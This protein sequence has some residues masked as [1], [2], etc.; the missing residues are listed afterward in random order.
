MGDFWK[1]P[2]CGTVLKKSAPWI[3][4]VIKSGGTIAGTATC[5]I[6]NARFSQYDVYNGKYD[7]GEKKWWQFEITTAR[8]AEILPIVSLRL[9]HRP[10]QNTVPT[11]LSEVSFDTV[12]RR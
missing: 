11:R 9:L 4:D 5:G 6:C 8:W 12:A 7:V 10:G 2:K 3:E 1:C